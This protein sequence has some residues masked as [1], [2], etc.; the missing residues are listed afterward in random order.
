MPL[1]QGTKLGPYEIL[2]P[3]GAGGMGE[4]YRA[5]DTRLDRTVALK[6]LPEQFFENRESIARFEREAKALAAVS[7]PNIAVVYSF[8]E[9]SGRYLLVQ[10]LLEG[11]TLRAALGRGPLPMRRSL[12]IAAQI[13]D[14]LAAAHEK[15]M[16][17]RDVKPENVFA[18]TDGRVKVLDFG[19]ARHDASRRDPTDTRSPTLA[20]LSEKGA[21]LGTVAYMS[22]EQARGEVVDF[23]SDQFSLGTVLYEMLTGTRPF[24]AASA[25]ET[26]T[27][28]IRDEPEPLEKKAPNVPAPVRWIVDR[29]LAKERVG[30]YD[31]THDL[32]R[33]LAT[34]GLYL[35]ETTSGAAAALGPRAAPSGRRSRRVLLGAGVV[36]AL[37]LAFA[38]GRKTVREGISPSDVSFRRLTFRRGNLLRAR[39]AP[40]GKTVV[41]SAAW[42]GKPAEL[43]SVR[44]DS[45]ES[46]ALGIRNADILSIS[47][48]GE[49]AIL[50][51]KGFLLTGGGG[52]LARLPLG[53]GAP[54]EIVEGVF[55]ASWSPDG[56][57]LALIPGERGSNHRLE[58]PIGKTLHETT[59]ELY[60]V[61]AS[62]TGDLVSFLEFHTLDAG[63][64]SVADR[65]GK[66]RKLSGPWAFVGCPMWRPDGRSIVF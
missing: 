35:S 10:E 62:P 13:A 23:R 30:R 3:L 16:V 1:A 29:C 17:H 49:L 41:Y 54:R 8:E 21:V 48:K 12:G 27:A 11:E 14:G 44:T 22:P 6:V 4:V 24:Q 7:H 46:Q 50:L 31:S 33:D 47:S 56:S 26:L 28:I 64:V 32:A 39:F 55:D 18:T 65:G 38:F 61:R 2:A 42:D 66:V 25:P 20:A 43:F 60:C 53:G 45:L 40:D 15:G 63:F 9:V 57:E 51:K 59:G 52:M 37:F 36:A 5:R 34:C 58:Y 19:L